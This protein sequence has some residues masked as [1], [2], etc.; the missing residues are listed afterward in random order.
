MK[1]TKFGRIKGSRS[2]G[3]VSG[4][5]SGDG[6][7]QCDGECDVGV[8]SD[9]RPSRGEHPG[10]SGEAVNLVLRNNTDANQLARTRGR[11]SIS[12][13]RLSEGHPSVG[14]DHWTLEN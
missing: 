1:Q 2:A 7:K 4:H 14:T 8:G 13:A 3:V 6:Y 10:L 5:T 9:D 11:A 12:C